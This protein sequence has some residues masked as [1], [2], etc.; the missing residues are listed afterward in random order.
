MK[1]YHIIGICLLLLQSFTLVAQDIKIETSLLEDKFSADA[2]KNLGGDE[3]GFYVASFSSKYKFEVGFNATGS[4]TTLIIQ[5]YSNDLKLLAEKAIPQDDDES[6]EWPIL[7]N[8]DV[9][10][11]SRK[12]S[13]KTSSWNVYAQK[14]EPVKLYN[15]GAAALLFNV[16]QEDDQLFLSLQMVESADK[17]FIAFHAFPM[18]SL[19]RDYGDKLGNRFNSN[20]TTIAVFGEGLVKQWEKN[21]VI[22]S[23]DDKYT[24]TQVSVDNNGDVYILGWRFMEGAKATKPNTIRAI[25]SLHQIS[26]KG[27]QMKNIDLVQQGVNFLDGLMAFD[28]AGN[29][30]VS[31]VCSSADEANEMDAFYA[32][33]VD[34]ASLSITNKSVKNFTQDFLDKIKLDKAFRIKLSL[35]K[36]LL[37]DNGDFI[38]I[39]EE[40]AVSNTQSGTY[41]SCLTLITLGVDANAEI[42]WMNAVPKKQFSIEADFTSYNFMQNGDKLYLFYNGNSE[43]LNAK[44]YRELED[45][46]IKNSQIMMVTINSDGSYKKVVLPGD[47]SAYH[48]RVTMSQQSADK[49]F[50]FFARDGKKE[51]IGTIKVN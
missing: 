23:T 2:S 30:I 24:P 37:M 18:Q 35:D 34:K 50:I 6:L 48:L 45:Y 27:A 3:T 25:T 16:K 41:F 20:I 26:N 44:N 9:Y 5:K 12:Y 40:F 1:S 8:G 10:S 11:I 46:K 29:I 49:K 28:K 13:K 4:Q 7:F 39:I 36:L 33:S 19:G 17:K 14:L 47:I 21:V 42:V 15:S 38:F 22:P 43:N 31:G 51:F 32:F